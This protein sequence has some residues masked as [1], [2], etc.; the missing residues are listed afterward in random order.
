MRFARIVKMGKV[1]RDT[2]KTR[3]ARSKTPSTTPH[4]RPSGDERFAARNLS[5]AHDGACPQRA[6]LLS[7]EGQWD[8]FW[9]NPREPK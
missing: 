8:A 3:I 6:M 2:E 1:R 7:E 4:R 9:A 5:E